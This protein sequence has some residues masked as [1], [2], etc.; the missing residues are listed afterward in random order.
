MRLPIVLG[1]VDTFDSSYRPVPLTTHVI[2]QGYIG[3]ASNSQFRFWSS[4][5]RNVPELIR[6]F[7][8]GR[9]AIVFCH[10]RQDTETLAD[11]LAKVNG[12]SLHGN[13]NVDIAAQTKVTKLQRVLYRG[14]GYHHASLDA[15][16]RR[17]I[18]SAFTDGKI[19]VLCA[20][21]TLAM[22]VNLPAH[23][24]IVKGTK[25]WRGGGSGYQDIDQAS[26]VSNTQTA[27]N[28]I[29]VDAY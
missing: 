17:L 15:D 19:R 12:I 2:G 20:T 1:N 4:L 24:V 8:G 18:E 26:L 14:I 23:L 16:E 29:R 6:R 21:S 13:G 22:G 5:N 25:A 28:I 10:S 3:E 27:M 7:S 9:P 11:A